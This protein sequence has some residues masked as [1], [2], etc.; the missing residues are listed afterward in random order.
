MIRT[1]YIRFLQTLNAPGVSGDV[2]KIANL[3]LQ[4]LDELIPLS[5]AQ[6][7]RVKE[8]VRLAQENWCSFGT[9]FNLPSEQ[10]ADQ[11]RSIT[12]LKRLSVGPF[13]GFAREEVFDLDSRLVLIYGPNGTG[14]SSFCEA[15]EY[16]L[17]GNVAEAENRR[18]D[19]P[20]YLKNAHTRKFTPPTLI[21]VDAQGREIQVTANE[22][23]YR[24][25]FIEKNRIDNFSRIAAQTPAKQ[26]ELIATLF[27]VDAFTEFVHD[28]T[29]TMDARYIDLEGLKAKELGKKRWGLAGYQQQLITS[30]PNNIKKITN[31]GRELLQ[32]YREGCTYPQM[33]EEINGTPDKIGLIKQLEDELQT[34]LPSKS[35]LT[36]TDL[37]SLKQSIENQIGNLRTKQEELS[38]VSLQVSFKQ[39]YEAVTQLKGGRAEKCPA[40]QT[41]LSKVEVNPFDYADAE[42]KKLGHLSQLQGDVETLNRNIAT[43][44]KRLSGMIDTCCLRIPENNSLNAIQI[45]DENKITI[46]WWQSLLQASNVGV[47]PLQHLANQVKFLEELDK[48]IDIATASRTEKRDKLVKLRNL[49]GKFAELKT[50]FKTEEN[51]KKEAEKII[52]QFDT[53]NAQLLTESEA[54]KKVVVQNKVIANAYKIFFEKLNAHLN[55]LPAQLVADLGRTVVQ[56]YNAFNSNDREQERLADIRLPLNQNQCLEISFKNDP[57]KYFDALHI[58][59]EGHIRCIGL[60]ILTAKNIKENCPLL[61]FDDPV[62]AFDDEHRYSIRKTLFKD[63]FFNEKQIILA[64]HGEEFFYSIHQLIGKDASRE[65][66]SYL[67]SPKDDHHICVNSSNMPTNYVSAARL[68]YD[69]AKYRDSLM[70]ARR[71]FES[72]LNKA[73]YHYGKYSNKSDDLISVSRRSPDQHWDLRCLAEN[74]KSKF[75]KSKA[76]IPNKDQIINSINIVIGT[77]AKQA[78]WTYLNKGTHDETDLSEFESETVVQ[79]VGALEQL[80]DALKVQGA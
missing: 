72:L 14:K 5:T 8:I 24:F 51:A 59:S 29:D 35:N 64:C 34:Q 28:F 12:K 57:T 18:F 62:N 60:A 15:L 25:C 13:R 33:D 3:V 79:I 71:A 31:E 42:L 58:L 53:E 69:E 46:D 63:N 45:S 17:L 38:K 75:N 7:R 66:R 37:K 43:F 16:G 40:C 54:E 70:S 23:L 10:V 76:V 32:N 30:I 11:I 44:L 56:L 78:P 21:G 49:A 73:W 50:R 6:G 65:A 39:L 55:D 74:L 52:S 61:I 47:T 9:D 48:K 4:N 26:E 2:R 68:L 36:I 27:G 41:P 19:Q 77:D 22:L 1:E 80:D 67:F 20:D